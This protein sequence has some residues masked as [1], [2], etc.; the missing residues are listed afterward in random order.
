MKKADPY[1]L[2]APAYLLIAGFLFYPMA[3]VFLLSLREYQLM[4]P[5]N[6]PFVGLDQYAAMLQSQ[7]NDAIVARTSGMIA[8]GKWWEVEREMLSGRRVSRER[9]LSALGRSPAERAAATQLIDIA[10]QVGANSGHRTIEFAQALNAYGWQAFTEFAEPILRLATAP[11]A[12]DLTHSLS[13]AAIDAVI[14]KPALLR[15]A[16][17]FAVAVCDSDQDLDTS[18]LA[19]WSWE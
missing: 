10:P 3:T 18:L 9:L 7:V 5:L 14:R 1:L 6:T 16:R 15:L 19:E 4:D 13:A 8:Y 2:L 12:I 11:G 17:C